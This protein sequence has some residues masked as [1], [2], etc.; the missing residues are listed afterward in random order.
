MSARLGWMGT[1]VLCIGVGACG[2]SPSAP[3]PTV[4]LELLAPD[5]FWIQDTAVNPG[6]HYL[7]ILRGTGQAQASAE[8]VGGRMLWSWDLA[9]PPVDTLFVWTNETITTVFGGSVFNA[10][11]ERTSDS[12]A[13]VGENLQ[14][15]RVRVEFDYVVHP[16]ES[17]HV[18]SHDSYCLRP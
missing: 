11:D 7:W 10:G 6:C 18:V 5:T 9:V 8:L 12:Y 16:G 17:R 13:T 14:D 2:E 3:G 1:A 15:Y 4:Q